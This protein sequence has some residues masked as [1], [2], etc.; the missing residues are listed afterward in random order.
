[1]NEK[2][3]KHYILTRFNYGIYDRED[4]EDWMKQRMEL[5]NTTAYSVLRQDVDFEWIL[6]IDPRTPHDLRKRICFADYRITCF[7]GHVKDVFKT[8]P[9]IT[10]WI[11]TSRLD[12]DDLYHPGALEAIQARFIQKEIVIDLKYIQL[13]RI[14]GSRYTSGRDKPNSP[15]LSLI[16]K[17]DHPIRTCYARPHNKMAE[18]YPVAVFASQKPLACMVVHENNLG[19]KIVG[20]RI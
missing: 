9:T 18:D 4:A 7:E 19:N 11:I 8:N 2:P 17:T 16:E 15:F 13:D 6:G 20:E 14:T 5:F 3:F 12:N 1:M 10:P